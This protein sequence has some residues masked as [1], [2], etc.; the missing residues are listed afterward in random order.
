MENITLSCPTEESDFQMAGLKA[1]A[2]AGDEDSFLVAL[3]NLDWQTR[4]AKDYIH[5]MCLALQAGAHQAARRLS[6]EGIECFPDNSELQKYARVFAQP[7]VTSNSLPPDLTLK[8]NREWLLNNRE[9]YRGKW[10]AVRNGQLLGTAQS[11]QDL[12]EQ[13]GVTKG[14]L[15]TMVY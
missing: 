10:V 13:I 4:P 15:L 12:I 5:A 6:A 2:E 11:L 8:T 7:K 3:K 14:T 1:A 9:L